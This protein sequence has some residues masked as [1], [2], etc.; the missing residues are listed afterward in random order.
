M[1]AKS[2]KKNKTIVR[3]RY[4]S[5]QILACQNASIDVL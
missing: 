4:F 5:F 3:D 1:I 2:K